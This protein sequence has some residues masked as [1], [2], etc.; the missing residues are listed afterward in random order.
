MLK[1]LKDKIYGQVHFS[2]LALQSTTVANW[3]S[4]QN[5]LRIEPSLSLLLKLSREKVLED[6][7]LIFISSNIKFRSI[8]RKNLNT[9]LLLLSC[10][11][12]AIPECRE[13]EHSC[14]SPNQLGC[15]RCR[16]LFLLILSVF[17]V[18]SR[19]ISSLHFPQLTYGSLGT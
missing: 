13:R 11:A 9:G 17:L 7:N 14:S 10:R 8:R 12:P 5:K 2:W 3:I 1:L 18:P 19:G 16:V 6:K 4:C 15:G